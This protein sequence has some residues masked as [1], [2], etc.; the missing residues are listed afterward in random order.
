MKRFNEKIWLS[1]S[2]NEKFGYFLTRLL[3]LLSEEAN[4]LLLLLNFE[5]VFI[6]SL[7][8]HI[9]ILNITKKF[10]FD[11]LIKLYCFFINI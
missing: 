8:F 4:F 10:L 2:A 9:E 1:L 11:K 3:A 6:S 5:S 7:S